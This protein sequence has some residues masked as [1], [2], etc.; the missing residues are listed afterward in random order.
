MPSMRYT[1][2]GSNFRFLK[3]P[4]HDKHVFPVGKTRFLG[5]YALSVINSRRSNDVAT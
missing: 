1:A 5:S 2:R 3:I 4:L